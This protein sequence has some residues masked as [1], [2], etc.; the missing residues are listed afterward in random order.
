M[1]SNTLKKRPLPRYQNGQSLIETIVAIF[2]LTTGLTSGL[3]LAIYAFGASANIVE[4]ITATGLA[5]EGI[6]T[7]RRFRDSNWLAGTLVDCENGQKCYS[8]WLNQ[9]YDIRGSSGAGTVYRIIFNPDSTTSK[10]TIIPSSPTDDY[11]LYLKNSLGISNDSSAAAPLNYFRKMEI[12]QQSTAAPYTATSPLLLVR[13]SV[14]WHGKNCPP[15]TYLNNPS[16]TPCK[17]VTEEYLTN[18]KNY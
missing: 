17:I 16:D 12:I 18:W 5:R 11:R 9:T 1:K 14:W 4:Q 8:A 10:W 15:V 6:E 3:S 7:I 13:S 2:V